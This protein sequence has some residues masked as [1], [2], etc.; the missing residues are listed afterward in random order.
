VQYRSIADVLLQDKDTGEKQVLDWKTSKYEPGEKYSLPYLQQ[1]MGQVVVHEAVGWLVSHFRLKVGKLKV[2]VEH[3]RFGVR[4]REDHRTQ[5]VQGIRV[6]HQQIQECKE[7][8]IFP[9]N[10]DSCFAF[11]KPCPYLSA[12]HAGD[13]SGELTKRWAPLQQEVS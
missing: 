5:W 12:C 11:G 4:V 2:G 1:Q 10:S 7:E 6:V 3:S 13:F 9:R 8:G